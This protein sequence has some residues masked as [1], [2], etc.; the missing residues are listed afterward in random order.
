MLDRTTHQLATQANRRRVG[1]FAI[2][3]VFFGLVGVAM[4]AWIVAISW[5]SWRLVAWLIS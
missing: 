4:L 2:P 5:V 1:E 3:L